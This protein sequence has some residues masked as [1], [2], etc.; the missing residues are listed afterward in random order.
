MYAPRVHK[1]QKL[2]G[3][4]KKKYDIYFLKI[5][6]HFKNSD[7]DPMGEEGGHWLLLATAKSGVG[8]GVRFPPRD[9]WSNGCR[10]SEGVGAREAGQGWGAQ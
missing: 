3:R 6:T 2:R 9:S 10:P 4:G 1:L 8:E 7:A 5:R